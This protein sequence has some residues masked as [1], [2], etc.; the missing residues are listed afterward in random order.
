MKVIWYNAS[1]GNWDSGLLCSIFDKHPDKF[2]QHNSKELIYPDKAIVII[3]G[4]PDVNEVSYYLN[5]LNEATV[6][7]TSEEDAY[8]NW[9]A[10]PQRHEYWT[11][12]YH[13]NKSGIATRLL[14]G[15]PNRIKDY[16]I[17]LDLPKKYL[18]SFVGQVQNPSRQQCVDVLKT[19]PDGFLHIVE[20]FGGQG[21]GIEYQ[22]Y[23]DIMCQSKCVICPSGSMCVDS[24]RFYEA[25][26]C[27]AIP[28]TEKRSPR[29][30]KDFDYWLECGIPD[31]FVRVE[32]WKQI[33]NLTDTNFDDMKTLSLNWWNGY[34]QELENKLLA[35]CN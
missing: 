6:I 4:R 34:K 8:F 35:L 31:K 16:K 2:E 24:F 5:Q 17:N 11:Q 32:S 9:K 29:D 7:L 25:I 22:E 28:I 30:S 33:S 21:N 1:K 18:W 20:A 13:P 15:A 26:E 12:Y 14:L 10:L 3:V 27:G 23:L 19:L